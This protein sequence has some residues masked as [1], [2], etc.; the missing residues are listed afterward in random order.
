MGRYVA[1]LPPFPLLLKL[2]SG[3]V[4]CQTMAVLTV[5]CPY[6]PLPQT[7][8]IVVWPPMGTMTQPVSTAGQTVVVNVSHRGLVAPHVFLSCLEPAGCTF[9]S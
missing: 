4:A 7:A 2:S 5:G 1:G 9:G 8:L 6:Q 3:Q